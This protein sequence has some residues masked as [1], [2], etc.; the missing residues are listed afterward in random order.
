M[1]VCLHAN[2][3][4]G[5]D[6]CKEN[7]IQAIG[8]VVFFTFR[9][10]HIA[11]PPWRIPMKSLIPAVLLLAFLFAECS[12][13]PR[14][15]LKDIPTTRVFKLTRSQLLD[16]VRVYSV[17]EGF[18]LESSEVE[19]GRIIG[20]RT[21]QATQL[22]DPSK[23]IIMNLRL[24]SV[25]A[26]HCE[27]TSWFRFSSVGNALTREEESILRDCYVTLYDELDREAGENN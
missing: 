5:I 25:D 14:Q 11:S 15:S 3:P 1:R 24:V 22:G 20:R 7:E 4:S 18:S 10:Y 23:L 8:E 19:S 17:K 12:T 16:A 2:L 9:A 6:I 13:G 21:L 26:A 27:V